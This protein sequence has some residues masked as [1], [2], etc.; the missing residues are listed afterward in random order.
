MK[1]TPFFSRGVN[2]AISWAKP[3]IKR[4]IIYLDHEALEFFHSLWGRQRKGSLGFGWIDFDSFRGDLES[5]KF[6]GRDPES[7]FQRIHLQFVLA[8]SFK[9]LS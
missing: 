1:I 2:A 6:A 8:T 3:G 4:D 5:Q 9:H 7:A